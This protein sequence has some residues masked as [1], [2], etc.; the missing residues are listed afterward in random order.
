[1]TTELRDPAVRP[2]PP[3]P[4]STTPSANKP[5]WQLALGAIAVTALLWVVGGWPA[6]LIVALLLLMIMLH[7]LGHFVTARLTG[8]K[9]TE[10]FVGFGP[11]LWSKKFGDTEF[12]I[13]AGVLGG[14]V[15]IIGMTNLE[16]IAP[17]DEARTFRAA[18]F[19]RRVLVASAGSIMHI[20]LALL[21]FFGWLLAVGEITDHQTS[22]STLATFQNQVSPAHLAQLKAGDVVLMADGKT[23]HNEAVLM[24]VINHHIGQPVTLVVRQNGHLR[25]ATVTPV[26]GAAI[27]E[28]VGNHWVTPY[29]T[30]KGLIGVEL[31]TKAIY[32]PVSTL[33]AVP[34]A[35]AMIGK[36]VWLT[37][38]SLYHRF[39]PSG[40]SSLTHQLTNSQAANN[41]TNQR[42][43]VTSIVGIYRILYDLAKVKPVDLLYLFG[44]I[45]IGIGFLNMLPML[46]LDGGYVAVAIYERVRSRRGKAPYRADVRKLTPVVYAFVGVLLLL[47]LSSVYL[48]IT[49]PIHF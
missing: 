7:E 30:K 3:A 13:K 20:L 11:K 36:I 40:V 19:P 41:P 10:F 26:N 12:G 39:T 38:D 17:E 34:M 6:P 32:T 8:M 49:H 29:T 46:P 14:Y 45:N 42:N 24:S 27:K 33:T 4:E 31:T 18:T 25:T 22:I 47:V 2:A 28:K 43:R 35:G 48:D 9:A 16:E 23:L 15:K 37:A 1:M 5:L 44:A 21:L